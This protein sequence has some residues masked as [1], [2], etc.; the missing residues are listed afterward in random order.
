MPKVRLK[1]GA[2]LF[3]TIDDFTDPWRQAQTVLLHH[4]YSRSHRFWYTWVPLLARDY[5]VLRLD[6]RGFGESEVPPPGYK[7][8]LEGLVEDVVGLLDALGLERV[9]FVGESLAG[10]IGLRLAAGHP[11]RLHSLCLISTPVRLSEEGA[12]TLSMG[13]G[14]WGS[15]FDHFS[16][17]EWARATIGGRF[18]VARADP[19]YIDWAVEQMVQTPVHV[20]KAWGQLIWDS[21]GVSDLRQNFPQMAVATLIIGG[22]S[23]WATPDQQHYLHQ[24]IAGSQLVLIPGKG[25]LVCYDRP[26]ECALALRRF[27]QGLP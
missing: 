21:V 22:E 16:P 18:D 3:Y 14:S 11:E 12:R 20:L 9:H 23:P 17:R 13:T 1:D 2:L 8:T 27:L 10:L 4:G 19:G 26:E 24:A 5:R 6:M 15:A 7:P 25:H